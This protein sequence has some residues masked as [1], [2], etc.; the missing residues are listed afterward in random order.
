MWNSGGMAPVSDPPLEVRDDHIRLVIGKYNADDH[1]GNCDHDDKIVM[2]EIQGG[3]DN[4]TMGN[5]D[6]DNYGNY[7][8]EANS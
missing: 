2:V 7:D 6:R 4:V 8:P 3:R 5:E 1:V